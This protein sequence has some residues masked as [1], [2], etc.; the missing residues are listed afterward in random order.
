MAGDLS[1][2]IHPPDG[3]DLVPMTVS[4]L[5]TGEALKEKL[6]YIAKAQVED[7]AVHFQNSSEGSE[8]VELVDETTLEVQGVRS[9]ALITIDRLK[10][11][12]DSATQDSIYKRG[13]LSYYHTYREDP[14]FSSD[15]SVQGGGQPVKL[16]AEAKIDDA[17]R[18]DNWTWADDGK[19]V[20]IFVE[21]DAEPRAVQAAG[22][23]K[24]GRVDSVFREQGFAVMIKDGE[25]R[26]AL[27]VP[28][29][30]AAINPKEC[31]VRVSEGKRVTVSLRKEN[32]EDAWFMLLE[33]SQ[34]SILNHMRG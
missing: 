19:N 26:F 12:P 34:A 24:N 9:G 8:A 31:K 14:R 4:K 13:K 25:R 3:G 7:Q 11:A 23:G 27:E 33:A 18:I 22:D 28:K 20:K 29:L 16:D 1:L 15:M 17:I 2:R 5:C 6:R 21:A 32:T 30:Y 10:A